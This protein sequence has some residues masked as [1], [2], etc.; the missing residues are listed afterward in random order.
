MTLNKGDY[1]VNVVSTSKSVK[2]NFTVAAPELNE[3]GFYYDIP[4]S[5]TFDDGTLETIVFMEDG[6]IAGYLGSSTLGKSPANWAIYGNKTI[7]VSKYIGVEGSIITV[8]DDGT[9]LIINNMTY[10]LNEEFPDIYANF[11]EEKNEYGFYFGVAYS[12]FN[13]ASSE[14]LITYVLYEDG[15][16]DYYVNDVLETSYPEG[17]LKYNGNII[18][19]KTSNREVITTDGKYTKPYVTRN[20]TLSAYVNEIEVYRFNVKVDVGE[21]IKYSKETKTSFFINV[22]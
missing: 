14:R 2:G 7:D 18:E 21:V 22:L 17:T 5:T 12:Y 4:Y 3:Y 20:V 11:A 9:K 19:W 6:S 16:M 8:S 15:S 1:E 13:D 10:V